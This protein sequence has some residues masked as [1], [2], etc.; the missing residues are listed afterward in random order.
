MQVNPAPTQQAT[1]Q[2]TTQLIPE[3]TPAI[4]SV[5]LADLRAR[6]MP[7]IAVQW[8]PTIAS[9]NRELLERDHNVPQAGSFL[10][11]LLGADQQTQ[12]R[13]R[14]ARPWHSKPGSS[15]TF[16]IQMPLYKSRGS[17]AMSS[18]PLALGVAIAE[19]IECWQAAFRNTAA[20]ALMLKW[21]NDLLRDSKKVAGILVEARQTLVC[22][23][24]INLVLPP[25]LERTIDRARIAQRFDL[26]TIAPGG[27]LGSDDINTPQ[28]NTPQLRSHLVALV[29]NAI[30]QARL[31]H[32]HSGIDAF[33]DRWQARNA[34]AN[35]Q[36]AAVDNDKVLAQGLCAGLGSGGELLIQTEER[37][38]VPIVAG[39]VS[40]RL[41]A[42]HYNHP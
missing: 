25:D 21:P 15:L 19:A 28:L 13:G 6:L 8:L 40:I 3:E 33:R 27:L 39:D 4:K 23:V 30:I 34:F 2:K 1:P 26:Q 18:L 7:Q 35:L 31:E 36:V 41:T 37:G 10:Y 42:A 17:A 32:E 20:A 29:S 11:Q 5:D 14:N 16:S 12:G 9:T 22:G 38:T 24:G